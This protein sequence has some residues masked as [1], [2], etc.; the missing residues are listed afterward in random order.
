MAVVTVV[1]VVAVVAV[2][3]AV[4]VTV[5][6]AGGELEDGHM[7]HW[8]K[9]A[10]TRTLWK[11]GEGQQRQ[12]EYTHVDVPAKPTKCMLGSRRVAT[13]ISGVTHCRQGAVTDLG[14]HRPPSGCCH[15]L[16]VSHTAV[17]VL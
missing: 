14:C 13:K 12:S 5:M 17:R 6:A 1:A 15:R 4:V 2:L 7:R 16:R 10:E 3:V 8:R 9:G 11:H